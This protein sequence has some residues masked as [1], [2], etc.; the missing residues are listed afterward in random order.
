MNDVIIKTTEYLDRLLL[1]YS[2]DFNIYKPYCIGGKEYPAYGYFFSHNEK[3]VLVKEVNMWSSDSYEHIVF[4]EAETIAEQDIFEARE[5]ITGDLERDYVRKGEKYPPKDH[6]QTILT[7]VLLSNRNLSSE[8]VKQ[9]Q[10]FKFDKG[11]LFNMRGFCRGRIIAASME[12]QQVIASPQAKE[13]IKI[14]K[15]VFGEVKEG[16]P[17]FDEICQKQGVSAF[18]QE[19]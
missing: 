1:K 12:S 19:V 2:G 11:Y 5:L 18:V 7:V 16:K 8:T 15:N 13:M 9:I 3:Y 17:G 14:F 4:M 10:K 6:M